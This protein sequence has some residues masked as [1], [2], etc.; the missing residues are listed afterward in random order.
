MLISTLA[1]TISMIKNGMNSMNP[2]GM[3]FKLGDHESRNK[4]NCRHL[5]LVGRLGI[6]AGADEKG[7]VFFPCLLEH[8]TPEGDD[9]AIEGFPLLDFTVH[10]RLDRLV[11]D[12]GEDRPH[13]EEGQKERQTMST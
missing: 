5:A 2:S 12:L 10:V 9:G 1:T 11:I 8:E 3:R 13:D 6:S 4:R 7:E